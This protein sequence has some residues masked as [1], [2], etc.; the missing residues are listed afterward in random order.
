M[1][2][3]IAL[4]QTNVRWHDV[5]ANIES[6]GRLMDSVPNAALYV[7]PE[8]WATGFDTSPGYDM[9]DLSETALDWMKRQARERNC[10]VAGTLAVR[11]WPQEGTTE[12]ASL[13]RNRFFF[14]TPD[15]NCT[16]YDKRNLFTYGGEQLTYTPGEKPV[17]VLWRGVRF[18]LQTCFDLRFPETVR[19][20]MPDPYDVILY[21]ANWPAPRRRA[22]DV[23]LPARAIE[24]QAYC[25][26]VN[27]TGADPSCIYDGGSAAYDA[28][29]TPLVKLGT[30]EMAA[31]FDTD[32]PRLQTFRQ[33][34][35]VL[36]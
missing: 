30:D 27:R 13:W 11:E 36:R 26:G 16:A 33:K 24:N 10:A 21:A 12:C 15:G 18:M 3:K 35:R 8:M 20:T 6:A 9:M 34:F 7:L 31:A 1:L 29:G 25:V 4:L 2:M 14:I 5:R 32:M 17:I 19:N 28:Y 22:W 23:L